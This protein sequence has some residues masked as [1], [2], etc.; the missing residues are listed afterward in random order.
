MV[1]AVTRTFPASCVQS[2]ASGL[3]GWRQDLVLPLDEETDR[4]LRVFLPPSY[5]SQPNRKFPLLLMHDGQNL[6]ERETAF[7]GNSIDLGKT[8]LN[9]I[10]HNR[11]TDIIAVG[12]DNAGHGRIH[13]YTPWK[14]HSIGQ[15]G[16]GDAYLDCIE[17]RILP[18][19]QHFYRITDNPQER[20]LGGS[21][22]GAFIS[23]YGLIKKQ[24][25]FGGALLMSGSWWWQN[26][27]LAHFLH[28]YGK[29]SLNSR[30]WL[31]TGEHE[32]SRDHTYHM[33]E[34]L[35]NIGLPE[36]NIAFHDAPG[37]HHD[38][39]SWASRL[40]LPLRYFFGII[41]NSAKGKN[42]H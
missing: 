21:S 39:P 1:L 18:T 40:H 25:L 6:F 4:T 34:T 37:G 27:S 13:E 17:D 22:L 15:G 38:E 28:H 9:E 16:G 2:E 35:K 3:E 31:D 42:N 26:R 8:I 10:S 33:H 36:R 14:D 32:K 23:L 7:Q 29:P 24:H 19:L 11:M 30:L 41:S 20:I 12:I 5:Y